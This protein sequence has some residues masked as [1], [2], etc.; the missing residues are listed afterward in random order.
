MNGPLYA[1]NRRTGKLEWVCDF[2]PHQMLLLEQMQDLPILLFA[3]DY[4]K[5]GQRA[6][7]G[8]WSR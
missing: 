7:T 3:A 8:R 1:L 5:T 2:V 6:S 4:S